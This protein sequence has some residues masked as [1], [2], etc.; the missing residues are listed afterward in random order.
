VVLVEYAEKGNIERKNRKTS[1]MKFFW[2][3]YSSDKKILYLINDK[4][5][6]SIVA[7][8]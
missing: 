5:K 8:H 7:L 2:A 4:R 6:R 1:K 3:I